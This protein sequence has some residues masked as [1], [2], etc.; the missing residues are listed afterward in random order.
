M[1]MYNSEYIENVHRIIHSS[2]NLETQALTIK[3]MD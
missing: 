3:K 1:C 2:K